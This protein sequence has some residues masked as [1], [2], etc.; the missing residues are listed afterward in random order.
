MSLVKKANVN[1]KNKQDPNSSRYIL[2][3]DSN[4]FNGFHHYS[5]YI[6]YF[7]I[8]YVSQLANGGVVVSDSPVP[9]AKILHANQISRSLQKRSRTSWY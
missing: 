1:S 7:S 3:T 8:N 2:Y 6:D 4:V 9:V 5:H